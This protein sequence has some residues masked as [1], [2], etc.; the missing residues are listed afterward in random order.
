MQATDASSKQQ[1]SGSRLIY[2][3]SSKDVSS[4]L[5]ISTLPSMA[6]NDPV[7]ELASFA[8][9]QLSLFETGTYHDFIIKCGK[10]S[11]KVHRSIIC[12]Q[13]E[14]LRVVCVGGWKVG[15]SVHPIKALT[16]D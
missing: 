15:C 7:D 8:V 2:R 1:T 16:N 4:I 14:F 6:H 3:Q 9:R 5:C 13:S 10:R 11:F 12:P